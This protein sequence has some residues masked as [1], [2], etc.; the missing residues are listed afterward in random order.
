MNA[1]WEP[2]TAP[3]TQRVLIQPAATLVNVLAAGQ[4]T[5]SCALTS[6]NVRMEETTALQTLIVPILQETSPARATTDLLGL[7]RPAQTLTNVLTAPI[8]AT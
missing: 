1:F 7:A 4:G 2:I 8:P 5:V 3:I 6:T